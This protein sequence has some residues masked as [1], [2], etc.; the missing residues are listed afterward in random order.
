MCRAS[1]HARRQRTGPDVVA[2][3]PDL[4][5]DHV[6]Q[7]TEGTV[8]GLEVSHQGHEGIARLDDVDEAPSTLTE[9]PRTVWV[10]SNAVSQP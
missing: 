10:P 7:E 4:A 5:P 3:R 1:R 6:C 2:I 8:A 9:R